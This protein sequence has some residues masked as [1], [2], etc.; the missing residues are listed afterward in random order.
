MSKSVAL[1]EG[2]KAMV[3]QLKE[4]ISLVTLVQVLLQPFLPSL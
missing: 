3:K 1:D 4:L 2:E